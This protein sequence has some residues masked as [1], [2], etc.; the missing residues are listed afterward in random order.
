[1]KLN[2]IDIAGAAQN[3]QPGVRAQCC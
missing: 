3:C 1:M 2:A